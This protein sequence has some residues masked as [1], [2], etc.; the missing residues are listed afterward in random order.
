MSATKGS[1]A[2]RPESQRLRVTPT[3]VADAVVELLGYRFHRSVMQMQVDAERLNAMLL[4][5]SPPLHFTYL[6]VVERPA[7]TVAALARAP[8]GQHRKK[9]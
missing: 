8:S 7:H 3:I 6:D 1:T 9:T 4:R 5:G 2:V